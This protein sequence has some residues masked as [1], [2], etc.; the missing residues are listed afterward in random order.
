MLKVEAF[1]P[2]GP[3]TDTGI[4]HSYYV[5][6][7]VNLLES[8]RQN[9]FVRVGSRCGITIIHPDKQRDSPQSVQ[10]VA[11][12]RLKFCGSGALSPAAAPAFPNCTSDSG[13]YNN[14]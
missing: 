10:T 11:L 13:I 7:L 2:V 5:S 3:H 1:V 6:P 9:S 4:T 8:D 14:I 12:G